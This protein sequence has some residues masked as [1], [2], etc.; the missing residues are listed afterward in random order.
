MSRLE[1]MTEEE[2]YRTAAAARFF[3]RLLLKEC[4]AA[5]LEE[6]TARGL[7]DDL[8]DLGLTFPHAA[9]EDASVGP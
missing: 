5:L 2:R 7:R 8:A 3:A 6:M 4:D 1:E 9:D